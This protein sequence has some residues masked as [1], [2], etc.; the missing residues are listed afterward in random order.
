MALIC[1]CLKLSIHFF[2]AARFLFFLP[3]QLHRLS[4]LISLDPSLAMFLS[5]SLDSFHLLQH[6]FLLQLFSNLHIPQHLHLCCLN[7]WLLL[8]IQKPCFTSHINVGT[9]IALY[10]LSLVLLLSSFCFQTS[11]PHNPC[12]LPNPTP[13]LFLHPTITTYH[14]PKYFATSTDS[15]LLSPTST[16]HCSLS[17]PTF[18]TSVFSQLIFISHVSEIIVSK[19]VAESINN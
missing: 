8:L 16:Q 3:S 19:Y 14:H 5:I 4:L 10:T 13:D 12:H 7:C 9:T 2:L 11:T 6:P 1:H 18:I 17:F 15:N